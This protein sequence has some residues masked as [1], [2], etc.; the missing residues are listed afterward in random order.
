VIEDNS[1]EK[2]ASDQLLAEVLDS[3]DPQINFATP[4][5]PVERWQKSAAE[6][7]L[8]N[9]PNLTAVRGL[10]GLTHYYDKQGTSYTVIPEGI[11]K[12]TDPSVE[13]FHGVEDLFVVSFR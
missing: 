3:L 10:D 13:S 11:R 12:I 1:W 7:R 6:S 9:N 8:A 2:R 4:Q 5:K